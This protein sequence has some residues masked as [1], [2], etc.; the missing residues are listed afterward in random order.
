MLDEYLYPDTDQNE[1]A[2]DLHLLFK[3]MS[4][5]IPHKDAEEG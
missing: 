1:T 2:Y 3:E 5:P 4:E